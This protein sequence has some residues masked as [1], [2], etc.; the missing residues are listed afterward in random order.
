MDYIHTVH[1]Y[2]TDQMGCVHHSNYIRWMEEARVYMMDQMGCSYKELEAAGVISPVLE[3][4]CQYKSMARFGEQV[5]IHTWL[6]EYNGIRMTIG[7]EIY[8]AEDGIL[9]TLGESRHCFL[10]TG[11]TPISLKRSYPQWDHFFRKG[12][13]EASLS[14]QSTERQT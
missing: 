9:K 7:Y 5:R 1:Y 8:G 4:R 2:E 6:K 10:G 14:H 13:E 3:V 11:G 12:L